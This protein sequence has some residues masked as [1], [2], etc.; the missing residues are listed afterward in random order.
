MKELPP[1]YHKIVE[2]IQNKTPQE[3][4]LAIATNMPHEAVLSSSFSW[5]DQAITHMIAEQHLPIS[6][7][8]LDTGRLFAETYTT[9]TS[10]LQKYHLPIIAY[11]PDAGQLQEFIAT[12]GPNSF[13]ESVDLRKKCC[14]IRKVAPLNLALKE[15]K[16]WITGIRAAH[17]PKRTDMLPVEWDAEHQLVKYHPLLHWETDELTTFIKQH[18]IPYNPLHDKG[19]VSIGCAPCTRAVKT[20]EDFRAGRWWWEDA[21]NKECGLHTHSAS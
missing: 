17:S 2:I 16:V 12:S 15:K 7:F 10:T 8:T 4:L 18:Q 6:L 13:Y 19:F 3:A 11:Y 20:V 9:W 5:E 14:Q 1:L 21:T